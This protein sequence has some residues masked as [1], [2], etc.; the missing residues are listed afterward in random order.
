MELEKELE[1]L[2]ALSKHGMVRLGSG[3]EEAACSYTSSS[4]PPPKEGERCAILERLTVW[5]MIKVAEVSAASA[6]SQ[7]PQL[8]S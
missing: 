4:A 1:Q 3:R 7:T 6:L 5:V 8:S 2:K